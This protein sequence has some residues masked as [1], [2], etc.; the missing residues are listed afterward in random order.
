[1]IPRTALTTRDLQSSADD[2][3]AVP[4]R[5]IRMAGGRGFN[6]PAGCRSFTL[7][8]MCSAGEYGCGPAA[9]A[10]SAILVHKL[11]TKDG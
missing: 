6:S 8:F 10:R 11:A 4:E 1:M 7:K 9:L 3:T 2:M 5:R